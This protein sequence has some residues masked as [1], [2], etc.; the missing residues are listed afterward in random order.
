MRIGPIPP[1]PPDRSPQPARH[2]R[3]SFLPAP[4]VNL[5]AST[6][7]QAALLPADSAR[8]VSSDLHKCNRS[9]AVREKVQ[10]KM[11][12]YRPLYGQESAG[13]HVHEAAVVA[14]EGHR[15]RRGRPVPMLGDDHVGF[16]GARRLALIGILAVQ[17]DNDIAILLNRTALT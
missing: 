4:S 12:P 9:A 6:L 13:G 11:R 7:P 3:C 15:H 16:A 10:P 1:T 8:R 14:L 5:P 2:N 17:K